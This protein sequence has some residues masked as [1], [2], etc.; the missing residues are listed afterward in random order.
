MRK[1]PLDTQ[2][3]G[4]H[5]KHYKI[6]PI[7]FIHANN[8]GFLEGCVVKR[9]CR[10]AMPGGKGREDIEKAMHELELLLEL[11]YNREE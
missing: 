2:V 11:T 8:L 7:E 6:Q 3:G 5:Y 4:N 10:H 1:D 9:L